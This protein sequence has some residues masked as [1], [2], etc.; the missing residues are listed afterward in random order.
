MT[1]Q[2][3]RVRA[4]DFKAG[5][6]TR[7]QAFDTLAFD[8][9]DATE[10]RMTAEGFMVVP[11][12]IARTGIQEYGALELGIEGTNRTVR[13]YRGPDEVFKP[14]SYSTFERQTLTQNHPEGAVTAANYRE[15]TAGDVHDV[16]PVGDGVHLGA[17]LYFKAKDAIEMVAIYGKNQLSCGYSFELDMTPGTSPEGEAYDGVMRDI[18]GNHVALVWNARGGAGLRVADHDNPERK[19]TM[20]TITIN[21]IKVSVADETTASLIER[22]VAA[23]TTARDTAI[24]EKGEAEARAKADAAA[25]KVA[26]DAAAAAKTAHDAALAEANGKIITAE[27]IDA[28]VDEKIKVVADAKGILGED[29]DGKGKTVA[30]IRVEA[31]TA[32]AKDEDNYQGVIA[33]L[34][35]VEPAKAEPAIVKAAF[36]AAVAVN[37][38]GATRSTEDSASARAFAPDGAHRGAA[39]NGKGRVL[40]YQNNVGLGPKSAA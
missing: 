23:L 9:N 16:A 2:A 20:H 21:G 14:E 18:V 27:A 34:D 3:K 40:K 22:E 31:L 38:A 5:K 32:V 6:P 39:G 30:A 4:I 35:G 36:G 24:R 28:L 25:L 8:V 11:A 29:F 17:N 19:R 12:K 7:W 13:L 33:I 26:T 10:R 15:V 37:A 1:K